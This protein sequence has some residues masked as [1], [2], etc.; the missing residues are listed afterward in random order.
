MRSSMTLAWFWGSWLCLLLQ[1]DNPALFAQDTP[2]PTNQPPV[3]VKPYP[4]AYCLVSCERLQ[5]DS[6][7]NTIIN[8][9]EFKFINQGSLKKFLTEPD[10]YLAKF[11]K[12]VDDLPSNKPSP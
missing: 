8:G 3:A 9:Q 10:K 2:A 12:D 1:F 6:V 11:R 7:V 4:F 5:G